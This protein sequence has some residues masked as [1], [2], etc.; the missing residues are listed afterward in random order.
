MTPGVPALAPAALPAPGGSSMRYA[1]PLGP[2]PVCPSARP[3]MEGSVVFGVVGGTVERPRLAYL[4]EVRPVTEELLRLAGP[5]P[6]T[7][8][9]RIGAPCAGQACGH[10]DGTACRLATRVAQLLPPVVDGLPACQLRPDCRWWQ[11]EGKAACLRCPQ[12]VTDVREPSELLRLVA[13]SKSPASR[14]NEL[15]IEPREGDPN[16]LEGVAG[17]DV[18]AARSPRTGPT[19]L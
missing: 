10:F 11:Q 15:G 18:A 5:V 1:L 9:F 2:A 3:E 6:P 12:V 17:G 7:I 8:I 14:P 13:G 16:G 19:R 4:D